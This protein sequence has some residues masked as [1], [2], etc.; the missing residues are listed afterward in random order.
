MTYGCSVP[1]R[2]SR[3]VLL[4]EDTAD[5]RTDRIVVVVEVEVISKEENKKERIE[6]VLYTSYSL[7]EIN[8]LGKVL[9]Y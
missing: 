7:Q 6:E 9:V 2:S 5:C 1:S 8:F 4:V 3:D